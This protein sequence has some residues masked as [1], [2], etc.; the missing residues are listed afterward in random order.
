MTYE[1]QLYDAIRARIK[2]DAQ[3][4]AE[5]VNDPRAQKAVIA[6]TERYV[7]EAFKQA[8]IIGPFTVEAQYDETRK[9]LDVTVTQHMPVMRVHGVL[10]ADDQ[11]DG[12]TA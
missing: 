9:N 1:Q 2:A 11:K 7:S 8:G 10:V 5:S 4:A 6:A 3:R 12:G